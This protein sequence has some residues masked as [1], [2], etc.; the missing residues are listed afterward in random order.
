MAAPRL[1]YKLGD[2]PVQEAGY[3]LIEYLGSGQFGEVWKAEAPG[4]IEVAVKIIDLTRGEGG[5]EFSAIQKVKKLKNP[6]LT[7]I[8][9]C[10][11]V[12]RDGHELD[13]SVLG[14][15]TAVR[16][17][18]VDDNG[19]ICWDEP[20]PM[21]DRLVIAMALGD[22]SLEDRLEE[23]RNSGS[24]G[25]PYDELLRYIEHSRPRARP[26]VGRSPRRE[27]P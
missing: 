6:Y 14:S 27:A 16:Q 23:C 5:K 13:E 7:P 2:R 1:R 17:P 19:T 21:P 18:Q 20:P 26:R 8:H 3:R 9:A 12:D 15:T 10:W 25:I 22:M 11:I 4:G 24:E